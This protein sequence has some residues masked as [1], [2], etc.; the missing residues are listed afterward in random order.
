MKDSGYDSNTAVIRRRAT[1]YDG[2]KSGYE[3]SGFVHMSIPLSAGALYSTTEDLLKWELGLFGVKVL[4]PASLEKM[5]TPFK[6]NYAF[7]LSV[8]TVGGHKLISHGGGIEGFVTELDYYPDEKLTVVVLENVTRAAPPGE[9]ARKLAAQ[10]RGEEVKLPGERK[11]ITLDSKVL[12]RYVGT[13]RMAGGPVM[14]IALEG[15]RLTGKL[16]NQP[17]LEIFPESETMFFL[18]AVDAEIEF[19]KTDADGKASQLTLH[20]NGRDMPA[21]R[22]DDAEAQRIADAA[23]AFAK[24]LKDQTPAPGGEAAVRKMIADLQQGKPDEAMLSP[25]TP[26]HQQLSQLQSE[27]G[28]FGAIQSIAFKGVGPGGADI[29]SVKSDKGA[30]EYRIWLTP[31]GKVEMANILPVQ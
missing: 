19:P 4:K 15:N 29:Y 11:E 1:G 26:I 23:A 21:K 8:E 14:L 2:G 24:R 31:D 9:I 18:K 20:Q 10:A 13:Y 25:G 7:G 28:Q 27:V 16:G 6:N 12:S 5:I 22:L 17:A 30:W 3:N